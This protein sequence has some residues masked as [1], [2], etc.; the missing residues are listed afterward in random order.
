MLANIFFGFI[1]PWMFG[2]WL[3]KKDKKTVLLVSPLGA[4]LA[5][6]FNLF[7]N[8]FE[9][10]SYKPAL[11]TQQLSEFP[12]DIGLY[13]VI[14]SYLVHSIQKSIAK[15]YSLILIFSLATTILE[16]GT[17]VFGRISYNH[18]WNIFWTFWSYVL[19]YFIIY[20]YYIALK[21]LNVFN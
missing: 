20:R 19:P 14:S 3:Y 5:Y 18:G 12:L 15:P 6:T 21:K 13:P 2:I 11:K 7:G 16:Y 1:I 8:H 9:L 17:L 4:V 10:W